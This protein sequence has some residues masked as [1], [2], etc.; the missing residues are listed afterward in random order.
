MNSQGATGC[1]EVDCDNTPETCGAGCGRHKVS[2]SLAMFEAHCLRNWIDV[3][4]DDSGTYKDSSTQRAWEAWQAASRAAG[5]PG[6]AVEAPEPNDRQLFNIAFNLSAE[7]GPEFTE[8]NKEFALAVI[9]E[10]RHACPV[11]APAK[12]AWLPDFVMVTDPLDVQERKQHISAVLLR[13]ASQENC[14]GAPYDQMVQAAEI[15]DR[16]LAIVRESAAPSAPSAAQDDRRVGEPAIRDFRNTAWTAEMYPTRY[17]LIN[18][19]MVESQH[20]NY[21]LAADYCRADD[22]VEQ[23]KAALVRV[24]NFPSHPGCHPADKSGDLEQ[25]C[26]SEWRDG[27]ITAVEEVRRVA[28]P[29]GRNGRLG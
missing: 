11:S 27:W 1:L 21:V 15:I 17:D 2:T 3:S 10:Y 13:L 19:E 7:F 6:E 23:L 12:T 28:L 24:Q 16:L 29:R 26:D 8:A 14:D 9:R 4:R 25:P 5:V 20:G 22:E 18:G